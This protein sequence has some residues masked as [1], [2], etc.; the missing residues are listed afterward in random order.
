MIAAKMA[1]SALSGLTSFT[2]VAVPNP[3]AISSMVSSFCTQISQAH[4]PTPTIHIGQ[5]V[6]S[7]WPQFDED[8]SK[9]LPW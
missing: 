2:M 6:S 8:P 7:R 9:E 5:H 4:L 3:V 1:D